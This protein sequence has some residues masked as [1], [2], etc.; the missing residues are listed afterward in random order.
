MKRNLIKVVLILVVALG[1]L[2]IK[3]LY[4]PSTDTRFSIINSVLTDISEKQ[5]LTP[6]FIK[7]TFSY[8]VNHKVTV[9][10]DVVTNYDNTVVIEYKG[11]DYK[12]PVNDG[13]NYNNVSAAEV[14]FQTGKSL[15]D[16][17]VVNIQPERRS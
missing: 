11:N 13:D 3:W 14:I 7:D 6:E 5:F 2:N 1:T 9:T 16:Y 10:C 15:K 17:K 8:Y 4:H 12:V